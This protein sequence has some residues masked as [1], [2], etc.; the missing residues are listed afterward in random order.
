AEFLVILHRIVVPWIGDIEYLGSARAAIA[1]DYNEVSAPVPPLDPDADW[2]SVANLFLHL[3]KI[4]RSGCLRRPPNFC[5]CRLW[6]FGPVAG[7]A[8]RATGCAKDL[9]C[10]I[11]LSD[12]M[13]FVGKVALY[14][15]RHRRPTPLIEFLGFD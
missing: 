4:K 11:A 3:R 8:S 6:P 5:Q 14:A 1:A 13:G 7:D 10:Q 2:V 15:H 9:S 12:N